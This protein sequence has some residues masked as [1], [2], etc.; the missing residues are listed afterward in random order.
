MWPM[1]PRTFPVML[2]RCQVDG[3]VNNAT[4]P[5][6]QTLSDGD[7]SLSPL[8]WHRGGGATAAHRCTLLAASSIRLSS[9]DILGYFTETEQTS[10]GTS[11][12][13]PQA[14]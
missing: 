5:T 3:Q 6:V 12:D 9:K 13:L 1:S 2:R 8:P 7:R 10:A 11:A 4:G 14:D